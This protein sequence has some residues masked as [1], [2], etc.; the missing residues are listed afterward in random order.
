MTPDDIF[1]APVFD[2][3]KLFGT[4]SIVLN[5]FHFLVFL[6]A[7]VFFATKAR[8]WSADK[9]KRMAFVPLT[10]AVLVVSSC[11]ANLV[12]FHLDWEIAVMRM[13]TGSGEFDPILSIAMVSN[14]GYYFGGQ[15][16]LAFVYVVI[17]FRLFSASFR[18]SVAISESGCKQ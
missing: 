2:A 18:D 6:P 15:I 4:I 11:M 14:Q 1:C 8:K 13:A 7:S 17:S 9:C 5:I 16:L 3:W 12:S 10:F